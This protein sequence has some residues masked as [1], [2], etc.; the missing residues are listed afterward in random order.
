MG[1][2]RAAAALTLIAA[3]AGRGGTRQAHVAACNLYAHMHSFL[4]RTASLHGCATDVPM[5]SFLGNVSD[6][7]KSMDGVPQPS[8][9]VWEPCED[10]RMVALWQSR[11]GLATPRKSPSLVEL[12]QSCKK[13]CPSLTVLC[14]R[15]ATALFISSAHSSNLRGSPALVLPRGLV[16]SH[17]SVMRLSDTHA[18]A[19]MPHMASLG[20]HR[21]A[22]PSAPLQVMA[23]PGLGIHMQKVFRALRCRHKLRRAALPQSPAR[24]QAVLRLSRQPLPQ[25]AAAL[26]EQRAPVG[27]MGERQCMPLPLMHHHMT[28]RTGLPTTQRRLGRAWN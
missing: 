16:L 22:T 19:W 17:V 1:A 11:S 7:V 25:A 18:L 20:L 9:G 12:L 10:F 5:C 6:S 27:W 8:D 14:A 23:C 26:A 2:E 13:A 15:H 21:W 3:R 4:A 24:R 28:S